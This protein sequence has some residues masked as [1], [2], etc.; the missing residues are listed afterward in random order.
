MLSGVYVRVVL[1][2]VWLL[3]PRGSVWSLHVALGISVIDG[4]A[5][6]AWAV[7]AGRLL[8]TGLVPR[9][10]RSDYMALYYGWIGLVGGISNLTSGRI[11]DLSEGVSGEILGLAVGPYFPLFAGAF[12]LGVVGLVPLARLQ[13]ESA[14]GVREF[15]GLFLHGNPVLA[16][17]SLIRYHRAKGE[18]AVVA[19]T[20]SLGL[21]KSP[22]TVDELLE[23]LSDPRF[24][25][26]FE[27]IISIA[28]MDPDDRLLEALIETLESTDPA[29]SV[30]AAWGLGRMGDGRAIEPLRRGLDAGYRSV[31]A[32]CAR[33]LATLEDTQTQPL[34]VPRLMSETDEGLQIAYASALGRLQATEATDRVLEL[35][36]DS[37]DERSRLELALALARMVGEEHHFIHLLRQ[38]GDGLGSSGAQV[39]TEL[40]E[41][42][43]GSVFG[44]DELVDLLDRCYDALARDDT[45]RGVPL[46]GSMIASL[47]A[48]PYDEPS[49]TILRECAGSL[50]E[51]GLQRAEYVLL[52][53][54]VIS[55]GWVRI[56]A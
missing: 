33:S 3:V 53:L 26:R 38:R 7:G 40:R 12:V 48:D 16:M 25:V 15:A 29:F 22:L 2:V 17:G 8:Y 19:T 18:E 36:R 20:E 50:A 54:H 5:T 6:M 28:R 30:M 45:E 44:D 13:A 24:N 37:E 46:L 21:A 51:H 34:L 39:L 49:R 27:A 43:S 14:V 41:R 35:L 1:P 31:R 32:H 55:A 10:R 4:L 47:P 42:L 56:D 23:A 9:A 11:L 52:A